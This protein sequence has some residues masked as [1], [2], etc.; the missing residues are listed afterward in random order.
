M[1][2]NTDTLQWELMT[3]PGGTGSIT[4]ATKFTDYDNAGGYEY[5]GYQDGSAGAWQIRRLETATK[6]M[7]YASG[8]SGYVAAWTGRVGPILTLSELITDDSFYAGS[9]LADIIIFNDNHIA[10]KLTTDLY[11]VL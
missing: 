11:M 2:W 10:Y 4:N 1:V 6:T 5:F 3:Q 9:S 8:G 7:R